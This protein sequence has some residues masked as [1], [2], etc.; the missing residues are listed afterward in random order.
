VPSRPALRPPVPRPA[1]LK[2]TFELAVLLLEPVL[3][4]FAPFLL[5]ALHLILSFGLG[6]LLFAIIFKQLPE[7][8][9]KWSDVALAAAISSAVFTILNYLFGVYLSLFAATTLA[10][11]AGTLMLLF[12]WIYLTN[13]FLL[14]GVQFSKIYA[15]TK[16][17]LSKLKTPKFKHPEDRVE[18]V[19]VKIRLDWKIVPF[20][21][22][23]QTEQH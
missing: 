3:G 22:E 15:E 2:P 1:P 23:N 4:A 9:I 20:S 19:D 6:T 5:R 17:S 7:L 10:G 18:R 14:F 8:N 12:L 16:G 11:T 13:L 21:Q